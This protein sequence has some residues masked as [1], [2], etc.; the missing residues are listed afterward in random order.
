MLILSKPEKNRRH[1]WKLIVPGR[2]RQK[3]R[4]KFLVGGP[5]PI[6]CQ[7]I[8]L[9][10]SNSWQHIGAS[11]S[12]LTFCS[13]SRFFDFLASE[14]WFSTESSTEAPDAIIDAES[15]IASLL[16]IFNKNVVFLQQMLFFHSNIN[17]YLIECAESWKII[18]CC[19][20]ATLLLKISNT[21]ALMLSAS[22]I[23]SGAS[24]DDPVE[25]QL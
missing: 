18:I 14:S 17:F 1:K 24:V 25:N 13:K 11:E 8:I 5:P 4:Q 19:W 2:G 23:A 16:L 3:F 20:K 9:L 12:I 7:F 22:I 10:K 6:C 21:D 15:I